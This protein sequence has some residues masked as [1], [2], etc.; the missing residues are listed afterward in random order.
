MRLISNRESNPIKSP[1]TGFD[2]LRTSYVAPNDTLVTNIFWLTRS[3]RNWFI[4][5]ENLSQ[6]RLLQGHSGKTY[7]G[8]CRIP[9]QNGDGRGRRL[10]KKNGSYSVYRGLYMK[11][12][13]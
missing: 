12:R 2:P 1:L 4:S 8:T 6:G 3:Q 5:N 9:R 11:S 10:G 13:I 7:E